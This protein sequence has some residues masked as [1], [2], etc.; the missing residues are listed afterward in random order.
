M[1]A[2][3]LAM[4]L[5]PSCLLLG[6]EHPA[7]PPQDSPPPPKAQEVV[8]TASPLN[9]KDVFDTPYAAEVITGQDIQTRRLSRTLPEALKEVPGV[10]AQKTGHGQGSP[11]IR[12]MTGYRNLLLID[13]IRLNTSVQRSGPNQYWAL[14]DSYLID[15][16]EVVGGP[17][18][19][20]YGSDA[21]GGT[22]VAYTRE[23]PDFDEGLHGHVRTAGRWAEAEDSLILRQEMW[24]N[25][26]DTALLLG[27]TR[28]TFGDIEAGKEIRRFVG[29]NTFG[30]FA[31]S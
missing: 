26:S 27:A 8:I 4:G 22:V 16:L 12:G 9:P 1:S 10:F 17:S 30:R 31:I 5:V 7:A 15:R 11:F 23:P 13:G 25:S 19:V 6:Q 18:S 24:G 14:V 21:L 28:K 20:L 29:T 3:M 2:L